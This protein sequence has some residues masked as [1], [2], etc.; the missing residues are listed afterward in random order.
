LPDHLPQPE[1]WQVD[2]RWRPAREVGGDFYDL[3][4]ISAH[5]MAVVIADVSDKGISAALYMTLTRTLFRTVAQQKRQPAE[6]FAQVNELLLRDTPHGMFVT[7]V[8]GVIDLHTGRM[9]YAN[10]GHNL[11]IIW[12]KENGGLEKLEKGS[13]PLGIIEKVNFVNHETQLLHGDTMLL[14]T[15]GITDTYVDQDLFGEKRLEA[16]ILNDTNHEARSILTTIDLALMDFQSSGQP[17]DDVTAV[18][19]HRI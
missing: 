5:Q 2:A 1:G 3:F 14:Y 11:P 12:K 7:A 16:A 4:W 6:I 17:A 10:A 13:M 9:L 15:D 8:L 18:T 19:I